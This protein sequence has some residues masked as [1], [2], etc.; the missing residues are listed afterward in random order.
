MT[1]SIKQGGTPFQEAID[2]FKNKV[3]LP[4][5]HWTD[6]WEKEHGRAFVVAGATK[7]D[8]LTDFQGAIQKAIQDGTTLADFRKDFDKIVERHGWSYNGGRGW[9][10]RVIYHTNL[11]QAHMAGRWQ[12]A[13]RL[14]QVRGKRGE[15]V[16]LKYV[17]VIDDRTRDQH[18]K[19]H[20]LILPVDHPF[21]SAHYPMNGWGCRCTVQVLTERDLKRR[22]LSVSDDPDIEY[23]EHTINTPTGARTVKAPE[24]IHPGFASNQGEAA[25]G[26]QLSEDAFRQFNTSGAKHWKPLTEGGYME[27][28]RPAKVPAD[29]PVA[30]LAAKAADTSEMEGMIRKA[31]GGEAEKVFTLADGSPLLVDAATLAEHIDISRSPFIPLLPELIE[32]P[33]E[34]WMTFEQSAATGKVVLRK[35]LIKL[36]AL[37]K[38]KLLVLV[39]NASRGMFTGWTFIPIRRVQELNRLRRG[40]LM[41]GK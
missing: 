18:R 25:W 21:W 36:V 28:G 12:Q 26:R 14:A 7:D 23:V 19:W 34:I 31:I 11:R 22:G 33:Y 41:W 30:K 40:R 2:T 15:K 27:A 5:S 1:T 35:R 24:G 4:T 9:R 20:G 13:Q 17:A 3:R 16:Y 32:D 10:T 6:I 38:D 39:A 29:K 37:E 8:L